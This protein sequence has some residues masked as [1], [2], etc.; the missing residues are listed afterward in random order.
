MQ[1]GWAGFWEE[2]AGKAS[3]V[4][5]ADGYCI[6][7]KPLSTEIIDSIAEDVRAKL[8]LEPSH[9]LVE[10]GCGAG[11]ILS[12]LKKNAAKIYG[13]DLSSGLI[14]KA[15]AHLPG[16]PLCVSDAHDLPFQSGIF[17]RVLCY[18]VF[19]Y[20]PDENYAAETIR[21]LMRVTKR[22]GKILIG[23]ISNPDKL[24]DYHREKERLGLVKKKDSRD[25]SNAGGNLKYMN[26]KP[27]FFKSVMPAQGCRYEILPQDIPGKLT[28]LFRY[29]VRINVHGD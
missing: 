11:M 12:Y 9:A 28:S 18:G 23:E 2:Q 22:G 6:E 15:A 3:S 1:A 5:E 8:R 29:D 27:D 25:N 24:E 10:A 16:V 21:E 17:D 20:F 26:Y 7:G 4:I 19:M 14:R 13:C